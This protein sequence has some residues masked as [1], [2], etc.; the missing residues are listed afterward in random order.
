M[1]ELLTMRKGVRNCKKNPHKQIKAQE[2]EA[3]EARGGA[4]GIMGGWIKE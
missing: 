2:K 4:D 1:K 3:R